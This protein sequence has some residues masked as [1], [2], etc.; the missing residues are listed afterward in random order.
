[1]K[2]RTMIEVISEA[3]DVEDATNIAGEYLKGDIDFGVQMR[4]KT[5]SLRSHRAKRYAARGAIAVVMLTML[6]LTG[7]SVGGGEKILGSQRMGISNTC[8][9]MPALKTKHRDAFKAEWK[10]K[11]DQAVLEYIKN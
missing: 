5:V 2:Y 3:S 8:T 1:M 4:C 11:K 6:F 10:A 9:I 7:I